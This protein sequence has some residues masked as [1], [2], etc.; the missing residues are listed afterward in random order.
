M[1]ALVI[2][3]KEAMTLKWS[4]WEDTGGVGVNKGVML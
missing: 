2:K 1:V 3:E 4:G